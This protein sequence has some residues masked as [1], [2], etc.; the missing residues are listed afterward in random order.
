MCKYYFI[1]F[2]YNAIFFTNRYEQCK[3]V[4]PYQWTARSV[5]PRRTHEIITAPLCNLTDDCYLD[6]ESLIVNSDS[7]WN[8]FCSDCSEA[9]TT[10]DFTVTPSSVSAPST[11]YKYEYKSA[12]ETSGIGLPDNWS[13]IWETE[14]D[15]N[16]IAVDIVC[17]TSRVE[18]YTEDASIS[19]GDL[20]SN[21]GGQTGLWIGISF[22][23]LMELIEMFYRLIRYQYYI[24]RRRAQNKTNEQF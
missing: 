2:N 13:T 17:E 24:L 14:F 6:A 7:I 3:C 20:L 16:Y 18:V 8:E 11:L 4:S 10:V 22:L 15:K 21:V 23:S 9:C 5:V 19:G 12:V 1:S